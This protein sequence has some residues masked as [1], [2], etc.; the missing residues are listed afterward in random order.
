MTILV[1]CSDPRISKYLEEVGDG[2]TLGLLKENYAVIANTGSIKYFMAKNQME[3]FYK[4]L[5]ILVPHFHASRI[6]LLNHTDCGFY[7]GLGQ[8]SEENYL[9][10]LNDVKIQLQQKYPNLMITAHLMNTETGDL[11]EV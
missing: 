10:D 1:R 3:D 11:K 5:D 4:Q 7:K 6:S 2:G 9:R 8:D